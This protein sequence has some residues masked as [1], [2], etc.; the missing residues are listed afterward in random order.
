MDC[1]PTCLRMVAK[2]YRRHYTSDTLRQMAGFTREGV[3]LFGISETAEKI[4]FQTRG[5]KLKVSQLPKVQLP[6]ILHW[7]QNHFVL[8][9]SLSRWGAGNGWAKVADPEKGIIKHTKQEFVRSW[10]SNKSGGGEAVGLALLLE[11]PA[12]LYEREGEKEKKL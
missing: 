7:N 4:G 10:A 8:L 2:S 12:A 11:P 6:C 9:L 3:S 5:V 1:G